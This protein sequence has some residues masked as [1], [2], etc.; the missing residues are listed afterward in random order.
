VSIIAKRP[1]SSYTPCPEGLHHAVAVDVIDLGVVSSTFGDKH[2]I[3][4]VWQIEDENTETRRRFEARK[5][6]NLSLHEKATLRK[7]LESWRGRKFTEEELKGFDLEKLLGANCQIQVVHDISEDASIWANVQAVVP[8]PKNVAKLTPQDYT[9]V[10]DRPKAQGNGN[11][12]NGT[13][14]DEDVVPF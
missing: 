13:N 9:R 5:Q 7:D 10:K 14:G 4:I 1:E 2:K 8:M 3:R 6:Y 11:G 12:G